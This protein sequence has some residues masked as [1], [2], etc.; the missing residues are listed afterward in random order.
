MQSMPGMLSKLESDFQERAKAIDTLLEQLRVGSRLLGKAMFG[1]QKTHVVV[2]QK[3]APL[4]CRQESSIE[5]K[6]SKMEGRW[7]EKCSCFVVEITRSLPKTPKLCNF[8]V[9]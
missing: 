1:R 2:Y 6:F 8:Q 9:W 5:A 7:G 3:D 4:C